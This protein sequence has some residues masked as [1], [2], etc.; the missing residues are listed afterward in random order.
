MSI[1]VARISFT[2]FI[3]CASRSLN[4]D[5]MTDISVAVVS[6]P[7]KALQ[8]FTTRPAPITSEPRLMVPAT[9]GTYERGSNT[10]SSSSGQ[11]EMRKVAPADM[12]SAKAPHP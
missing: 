8:S 6:R 5:S 11:H 3:G 10:H 4:T 1:S 9:N 7:Q 12:H 2:M